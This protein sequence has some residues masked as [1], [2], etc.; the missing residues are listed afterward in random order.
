MSD[1]TLFLTVSVKTVQQHVRMTSSLAHARM[2]DYGR[3]SMQ[4]TS[5]HDIT[6]EFAREFATALLVCYLRPAGV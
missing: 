5:S 4:V 1:K 3:G 2:K 6:A